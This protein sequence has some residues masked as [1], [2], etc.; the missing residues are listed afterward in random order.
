MTEYRP[1]SF[2]ILPLIVKNLLIIN[3]LIFLA[4]RTFGDSSFIEDTFA[5]HTIQ[6]PLFRPWQLVTYM[7]LHANF[8]HILSN[9]FVLWMFGSILEKFWG[10]RS[11][12]EFYLL[13]GLGAGI[14]NLIVLYYEAQAAVN[15]NLDYGTVWQLKNGVTIGASGAIFGCLVA[16]AYLFPN[17]YI[18]LYFFIPVKAKWLILAYAIFEFWMAMEGSSAG[19]N[20]AHAAHLGGALVGLLLVIFRNRRNRDNFY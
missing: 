9:M 6:S 11:F 10:A 5:L 4:Q 17:T 16:F 20:I 3:G 19:D 7:F 13:C 18:Y 14:C 8:M 2:Q 15:G 1:S 12:L